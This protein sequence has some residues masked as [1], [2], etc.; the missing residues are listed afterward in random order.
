MAGNRGVARLAQAHI[1]LIRDHAPQQEIWNQLG[2]INPDMSLSIDY[3]PI[4]YLPGQYFVLEYLSPMFL[5]PDP[6]VET[7]SSHAHTHTINR[8]PA[9][10]TVAPGDRVLVSM[11]NGS[12][13]PVIIGRVRTVV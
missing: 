4:P 2:T 11:V 6:W 13:N 7:E 3:F 12:Q 8:P 9:L 10:L 1:R 5:L